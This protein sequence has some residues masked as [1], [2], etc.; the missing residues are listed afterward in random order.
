LQILQGAQTGRPS[1]LHLDVASDGDITVGGE[2][3]EL[4][5]GTLELPGAGN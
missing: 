4:G 1:R 2:A 3:V 5:C